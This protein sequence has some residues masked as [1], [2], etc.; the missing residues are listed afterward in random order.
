MSYHLISHPL[1]PYV[2]RVAITLI[3]KNLPFVRSTIDL[4]NKPAWFLELSPTGKTPLL[5]L[6][7]EV[8]FESAVICEYLEQE[9]GPAMLETAALARAKQRGW[10]EFASTCLQKIAAFYLAPASQFEAKRAELRQAMATLDASLNATPFF[11][12]SSFSLVDAAFAPVFRYFPVIQAISDIDFSANL[13]RVQSW[14][15]QLRERHSV[16]A[17]VSADYAQLLGHFLCSRDSHLGQLARQRN[18][19]S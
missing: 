15:N 1:C 16:Q 3:E 17:A 2:Q 5:Q 4:A 10:I 19:Q 11:N 9:H 6:G 7:H 8:I 13:A 12:G 18:L 14:Q